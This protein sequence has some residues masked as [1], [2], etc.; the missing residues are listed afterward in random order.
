[1]KNLKKLT[2]LHSRHILLQNG[3]IDEATM[4][5]VLNGTYADHD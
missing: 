2:L 1:M 3:R 4:N 5:A